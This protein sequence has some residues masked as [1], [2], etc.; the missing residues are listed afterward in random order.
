MGKLFCSQGENTQFI[1]LKQMELLFSARARGGERV[2][3]L[4]LEL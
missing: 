3:A 1:G 2:G 4:S